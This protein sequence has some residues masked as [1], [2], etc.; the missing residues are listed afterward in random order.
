[1]KATEKKKLSKKRPGSYPYLSV[2]FGVFLALF[3]IGLF[4]LFIL[5]TNKLTELL[6]Q[7]VEVQVY[8]EKNITESEISKI[9]K[10]L[11][12]KPFTLKKGDRADVLLISK[13]QAAE[14][15]I[16]E[17]GEDFMKFLGDNPLRDAYSLKIASEFQ[18]IEEL[19]KIKAEILAI[20][21]VYEVSYLEN[22][23][24]SINKNTAKVSV[25]LLALATILLIVVMILINNT[26]KLALFSQRFL[27][28]SMQLVG[29]TRSFIRKPFVFRSLGHGAL[30]GVLASLLL[31]GLLQYANQKIEGLN[32]L[33]KPE[34][35]LILFG[36]LIF[37]GVI[38]SGIS[39]NRAVK[40]YLKLSLDDLY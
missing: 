39:T 17:T 27:I 34:D 33:Q 11:S 36:S 12:E 2:L 38:I 4:G 15:F 23:I 40:K 25:S 31:F 28:R 35:L 6:K 14:A 32:K 5:H 8:L 10:T 22:L 7:N 26:I 18:T 29:A 19:S 21:G 20:D 1:M 37:L 3:V 9:G 30:A 24:D 13:E 16:E